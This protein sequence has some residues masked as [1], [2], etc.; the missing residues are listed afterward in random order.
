MITLFMNAVAEM[1]HL[2]PANRAETMSVVLKVAEYLPATR[3]LRG[4]YDSDAI[5][6]VAAH[7]LVRDNDKYFEKSASKISNTEAS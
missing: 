6:H 5:K 3:P 7:D 2:S 1:V 4:E